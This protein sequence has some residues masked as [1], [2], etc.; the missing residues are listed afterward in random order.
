M[1][2]QQAAIEARREMTKQSRKVLELQGEVDRALAREAGAIAAVQPLAKWH[3]AQTARFR[4]ASDRT[5]D[6]TSRVQLACTTLVD[7]F[8]ELRRHAEDLQH[9]VG[10]AEAAPAVPDFDDDCA[11]YY[12]R[13][14][15]LLE[16]VAESEGRIRDLEDELRTSKAQLREFRSVPPKFLREAIVGLTPTTPLE[17]QKLAQLGFSCAKW[18]FDEARL[19]PARAA[20]VDEAVEAAQ[21]AAK[22]SEAAGQ[23]V[24]EAVAAMGAPYTTVVYN[25]DLQI[26]PD[27]VRGAMEAVTEAGR[28]KPSPAPKY[29]A[30]P[31]AQPRRAWWKR[32]FTREG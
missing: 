21:Q 31:V 15:Q 23:A 26:T 7:E 25:G 16:Q 11:A 29:E 2:P 10:A 17:P 28:P 13:M 3:D 18:A 12:G 1:N 4:T 8:S 9:L 32:L 6:I 5:L 14:Q 30:E 24:D 20:S 22:E 19:H 27:Q